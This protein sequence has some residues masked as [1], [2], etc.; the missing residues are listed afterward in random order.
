[1]CRWQGANINNSSFSAKA[2]AIFTRSSLESLEVAAIRISIRN[3][4]STSPAWT[5]TDIRQ[6]KEEAQ[7]G[8]RVKQNWSLGVIPRLPISRPLLP[9]FGNSLLPLPISL[10]N[11][12]SFS[13]KSWTCAPDDVAKIE[14]QG[15]GSTS[16]VFVVFCQRLKMLKVAS[17]SQHSHPKHNQPAIS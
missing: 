8:W 15:C 1:M 9:R 6:I 2:K 4:L 17:S 5:A 13:L 7:V 16:A 14:M 11:T 3:T 10:Y 12:V